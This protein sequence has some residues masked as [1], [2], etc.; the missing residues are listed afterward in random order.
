M[1]CKVRDTRLS[2]I[3]DT[4]L[5][6]TRENSNIN[7]LKD[8]QDWFKHNRSQVQPHEIVDALIATTP[9]RVST[10]RE[11]LTKLRN[12]IKKEASIVDRITDLSAALKTGVP[13]QATDAN[14]AEVNKLVEELF[15][16]V[17][18]NKSLS[19]EERHNA[20]SRI[21]DLII[22]YGTF[23]DKKTDAQNISKEIIQN[24]LKQIKDSLRI[25]KLS[26]RVKELDQ[27]INDIRDGNINVD[28]L[29]DPDANV[30]FEPTNT[31]VLEKEAEI[32]ELKS[33]Y[34]NYKNDIKLREQAKKEG[35]FG[36]KGPKAINFRVAML[37]GAR[38]SW[39]VMRT[40]KF[41]LDA[42]AFGVQLA[43]VVIPALTKINLN[44]L[45]KGDFANAFASQR[46][47]ADVFRRTFGDV[48]LDNNSEMIRAYKA[49]D[50][51]ALKRAKGT[52]AANLAREIKTDPLYDLAMKSDLKI[53]ES[54]SITRSEEMFH[55]TL[56]NK[57]PVLGLIKDISEDTMVSTL[58]AYR[59]SM[60]KEF[61]HANP[62][63]TEAEYK[64][65]ARFINVLTGTSHVNTGAASFILS[66]PRLALSRIQLAFIK[67]IQLIGRVNLE[68][69]IKQRGLRFQTA[70]D[71]F[72][73]KE[74]FHMWYGY[75]R[76]FAMVAA[77][78]AVTGA[79]DFGDDPEESDF[80]RVRAGNTMYD[81][82]GGMGAMY[83]MIAKIMISVAGPSDEASFLA[84]RR[85]NMAESQG[86]GISDILVAEL[87][88]K[89]LHPTI[90]GVEGILTGK[91]FFGKPYHT[92]GSSPFSAR[93]EA[94]LRSLL[95]ISVTSVIDQHF[96]TPNSGFT[97]DAIIN[98]FQ[99]F[100]TNTFEFADKSQSLESVEYFNKI[101][102]KPV[103]EYPKELST[104]KYENDT[105]L[106]YLRMKYKEEYGNLMG[107]II[108]ENPDASES[109]FKSKLKNRSVNLKRKFLQDN[110]EL[111]N[112]LNKKVEK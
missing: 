66:A 109:R 51:T 91:D 5:A 97:E 1:A 112:L 39:E 36:Y 42:S 62:G 16:L 20:T 7:T 24:S 6:L 87:I 84:K 108:E 104:S 30:E 29:V 57:V 83:R 27:K 14:I 8:I 77:L 71:T 88:K 50:K 70:A 22:N 111:I 89:K 17:S 106:Q 49:G 25:N 33:I 3:Y 12:G 105:R 19:L 102:A 100:G 9:K 95:P 38:E 63:L 81:F 13:Q 47:L 56:I 10:A 55:S 2:A 41:M 45:V 67:P 79:I 11:N 34:E 86:E 43:P 37:K 72:I 4:I 82:T 35:L 101:E 103:T 48:I 65:A 76:M 26:E 46:K 32:V 78:G 59:F 28:V 107:D 74:M 44:A 85:A 96:L 54:R 18:E 21:Q 80:L 31:A 53:S 99:F 40:L 61:Y 60:F 110:K 93:T 64:K 73:A 58:N 52:V 98:L 92:L 75:S 90:T 23:F 68:Q 69:S 15:K 94:A